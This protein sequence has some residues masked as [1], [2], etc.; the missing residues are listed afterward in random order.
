MNLAD[1]IKKCS[2][3]AYEATIPCDVL[4]GTV[5]DTEPYSVKV[6]EM[7]LGEDVLTVAEH[8]LYKEEEITFGVYERVVVINEGIQVGDTVIILRQSSGGNYVAVGKI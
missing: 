3:E 6:G 8:L 4:F 7:L 5:T 2:L 1:A